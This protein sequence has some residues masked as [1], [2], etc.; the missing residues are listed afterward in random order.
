MAERATVLQAT[1]IGLESTPGV[2]VAAGKRFLCTSINATPSI[3]VTMFRPQGS[4]YAT[5]ATGGKEMTNAE[6]TGV[7]SFNDL[8]YLFSGCLT[9]GQVSTPSGATLTR[10]WNVHPSTFA[11]D[12]VATFTVE[13]GSANGAE[14]FTHAMF[15][16][17]TVR[18]NRNGSE[19]TGS[20]IGQQTQE[21]ITL[22]GSPTDLAEKPIG[23][24]QASVFVGNAF[25]NEVQSVTVGAASAGTFTLTFEGETTA[26]ITF[27][28]LNSA[29]QTALEALK[30]IGQ[31]NVTVTGTAPTWV[32]TFAGVLNKINWPLMTGTA[33]GLTGGTLAIT[34]TTP[35]GLTKLERC[36]SFEVSWNNRFTPQMTV[37]MAKKSFSAV[38]ERAPDTNLQVVLQHDSVSQALLQDMR[39]KRTKYVKIIG[40]GEVTELAFRYALDWTFA[41]KERETARGDQEDVWANTLQ[42]TLVH[43]ST[44]NGT[45][46]LNFYNVLTA[47]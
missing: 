13:S 2:A 47:L 33:T 10:L 42:G 6:V 22:T 28:A 38:V 25:A 9:R 46:D 4:K 7:V 34:Q 15:N 19:V 31:G 21:P 5:T 45:C 41:I 26:P 36:A 12:D 29:V 44:L 39:D 23:S 24:D 17:L 30:T 27:D 35:G 20:L 18:F 32:V 14:K 43:D 8:I 40:I 3:P 37:D 11:A 16:G 1:Q